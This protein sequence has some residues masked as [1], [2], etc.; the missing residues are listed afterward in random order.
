MDDELAIVRHNTNR[1]GNGRSV[2]AIPPGKETGYSNGG[3][4]GDVAAT[5]RGHFMKAS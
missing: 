4:A 5:S 3:A 2:S 1:Q